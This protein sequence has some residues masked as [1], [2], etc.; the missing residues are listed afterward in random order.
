MILF[1]FIIAGT[2]MFN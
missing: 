1:R 2:I